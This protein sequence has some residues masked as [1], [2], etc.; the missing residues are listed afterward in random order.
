MVAPLRRAGP[1]RVPARRPPPTSLWGVVRA[2]KQAESPFASGRRARKR[3]PL[4]LPSW[5]P[6]SP[7]TDGGAPADGGFLKGTDL[8][9]AADSAPGECSS[10]ARYCLLHHTHRRFLLCHLTSES[11]LKTEP[12][13]H[14]ACRRRR[15]RRRSCGRRFPQGSRPGARRRLRPRRVPLC[16]TLPLASPHRRFFFVI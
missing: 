16:G 1:F 7:N 13:S 8:M 12:C 11:F 15:R 6:S 3:S 5:P 4:L 9:P 10:V 14:R 2:Q